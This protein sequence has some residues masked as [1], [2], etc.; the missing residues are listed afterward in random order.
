MSDVKIPSVAGWCS[1]H[2]K[3]CPEFPCPNICLAGQQAFE[4]K[5]SV[6]PMYG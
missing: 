6:I 5:P 1:A 4:Q 3:M 2:N